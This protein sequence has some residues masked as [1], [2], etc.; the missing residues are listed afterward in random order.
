MDLEALLRNRMGFDG[1]RPHQ[2]EVC[3]DLLA[4][5]DVLV[6]MPTGAGKSMCYQLPGLA[7]SGGC[8]VISPLIA[9]IEDQVQKLNRSGIAAGRIHSGM[10][11]LEQR[12]ICADY[13]N[14]QLEFLFLAPERLGVPGFIDFLAKHKPGL[15]AVDE[16]HC[17]SQWG[18]DFRP[19][20]RMLGQRLPHLRP[21]P[22]IALTATATPIVQDDIV[23][24][25]GMNQAIRHI[26]GFRRH[27]LAIEVAQIASN[28]RSS[29][30][31]DE[32][33]AN[34]DRRPAIVYCPTRVQSEDLARFINQRIRARPYHAGLSAEERAKIQ[35]QFL[36]GDIDVVCATVAFGMG[37]DKPDVRTVIHQSLPHSIENYYQ[38]IGRAGRDGQLSRAVLMYSYADFRIIDFFQKKNYPE[39]SMMQRVYRSIP[40][41]PIARDA[42]SLQDVDEES[43]DIILDKLWIHGAIDISGEDTIARLPDLDWAVSYQ[44]QKLH[45]EQQVAAM[46]R[47]SQS[48]SGCRMLQL[49]EHFG[50]RTDDH[51]PCGLCDHC[52][53]QALIL[54]T[55][56]PATATD[57][58]RI[59]LIRQA[60]L[61]SGKPLSAGQL[62]RAL[63]KAGVTR[64]LLEDYAR[65]LV[66]SGY[67]LS[68]Q[69]SFEKDGRQI[70]YQQLSLTT[71]GRSHAP[72]DDEAFQLRTLRQGAARRAGAS[73]SKPRPPKT[74]ESSTIEMTIDTGLY[75]QLKQWRLEIAK[76]QKIP[77]F[78][79]LSDKSLRA[80]ASAKPGNHDELSEIYG[81]GP[82]KMKAYGTQILKL[83][84]EA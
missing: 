19:D 82:V 23:A 8:L 40:K 3:E 69:K 75:E 60:L 76:S 21:A 55:L 50:D 9:L 42:L 66:E 28:E 22:I 74:S 46:Q 56:R 5:S 81:L 49:I 29:V 44:K 17:I 52:D 67:L 45:K 48:G 83:L 18:H 11:R 47:F 13:A 59:H 79:I 61:A 25:L 4:G 34:E 6:V 7:R 43:R 77:A 10:D 33:L 68:E 71:K 2:R 15:I 72:G 57:R 53:P 51:S 65:V 41:H 14:G 35:E 36:S 1:F 16:A 58:R 37:I 62:H 12:Q 30:T 24:Q 73:K 27:N 26:H 64:D 54:E 32:I 38:E 70:T 78:R 39:L 20:Y 80:I 84:T 31:R 63:D